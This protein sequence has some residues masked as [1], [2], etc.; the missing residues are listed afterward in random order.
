MN[1][2]VSLVLY[3]KIKSLIYSIVVSI[4]FLVM[5]DGKEIN[6]T[7]KRFLMNWKAS[8]DARRRQ[9]KQQR[10]L[11]LEGAGSSNVISSGQLSSGLSSVPTLPA[12]QGPSGYS[13]VYPVLN[14]QEIT[15]GMQG[16][17]LRTN[18]KSFMAIMQARAPHST[19]LNKKPIED[20]SNSRFPNIFAPA[21]PIAV[22]ASWESPES[23]A[24]S[25]P[26]VPL[27]T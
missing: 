20:I 26:P 16:L 10:H 23:E 3:L 4:F 19:L 27:K 5:L 18:S 24:R 7:A 25:G 21:R 8:R 6:E 13:G 1:S 14:G 12:I 11:Y 15:N 2:C 17:A 22:E 9:Q